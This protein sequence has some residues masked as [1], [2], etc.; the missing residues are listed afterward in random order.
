VRTRV[1]KN[2]KKK[3]ARIC[4]V[5]DDIK[6]SAA[7]IIPSFMVLFP[8][9]LHLADP[10][11]PNFIPGPITIHLRTSTSAHANATTPPATAN[12]T[13]GDA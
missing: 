2:E 1:T 9:I 6:I 11:P 7:G 8:K 13:V 5:R 12:A 4:A 3:A 10:T